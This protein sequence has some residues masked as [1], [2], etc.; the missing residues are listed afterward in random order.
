MPLA[1]K[2]W[3]PNRW[4]T[5]EAPILVFLI[6]LISCSIMSSPTGHCSSDGNESAYSVG[7]PGS[8]P[9]SGRPP[10]EESGNPLQCSCLENSIDRE[11]WWT[12]VHGVTD[13]TE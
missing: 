12:T 7:D 8:I 10:G 13:T 2:A 3:S 11:A 5:M 9:G 1:V 4:T 6:W